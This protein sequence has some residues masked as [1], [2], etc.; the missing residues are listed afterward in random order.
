MK[1]MHK[2]VLEHPSYGIERMTTC[3]N[4]DLGYP[5]N[6]KR[7]PRRYYKMGLQTIYRT[8][9]IPIRNKA[10]YV[11]PFLVRNLKIEKSNRA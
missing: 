8:A 3:L 7:V 4:M 6:E 2:Y 9:R 1:E 5:I 11:H 10:E